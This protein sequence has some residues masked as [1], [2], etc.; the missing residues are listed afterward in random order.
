MRLTHR[1]EEGHVYKQ[2]V[3]SQELV[4]FETSLPGG[5]T[6][7]GEFSGHFLLAPHSGPRH[8]SL[9]PHGRPEKSGGAR[10]TG[11]RPSAVPVRRNQKGRVDSTKI[12]S[13]YRIRYGTPGW[14]REFV[15]DQEEPESFFDK[16]EPKSYYRFER[17]LQ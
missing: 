4:Q 7:D 2:N 10:R 9:R 11:Y 17:G 8:G 16:S 3:M 14:L 13:R 1:S 6:Q 5:N 12:H 15:R